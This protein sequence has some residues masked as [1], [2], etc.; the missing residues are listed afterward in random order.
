MRQ[1]LS[2]SPSCRT[3]LIFGSCLSYELADH[4]Q[5]G[6]LPRR[7]RVARLYGR[8]HADPE[9]VQQIVAQLP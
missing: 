9:V 3:L 6:R 8:D 2:D 7:K 5:F 1:A 4:R